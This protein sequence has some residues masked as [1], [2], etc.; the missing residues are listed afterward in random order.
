MQTAILIHNISWGH[1]SDSVEFSNGLS[2]INLSN[3]PVEKLYHHIC[4]KDGIDEASPYSYDLALIVNDEILGNKS[5]IS[6]SEYALS[7]SVLNILTILK[8]GILGFCRVIHSDDNFQTCHMTFR[9]YT[10]ETDYVD[11]LTAEYGKFENETA[12]NFRTIWNNL[13]LFTNSS[14]KSRIENAL[15]FFYFS[16]QTLSLEQT[17]ICLSIVLETLFTPNSN[18]EL[19]H[20]IAYNI[21]NFFENKRKSKIERYRYIKK[22]YSIRS[23][24]VHGESIS[25]SERLSIKDYFKFVCDL[26]LKIISDKELIL[27][28]NDNKSRIKYLEEK[29]FT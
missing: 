5:F 21:A 7:T 9:L 22:Y 17:G 8:K 4:E 29:L 13:K 20:Q 1:S 28:F 6:H 18:N 15:N 26:L 11:E 19:T 23:K 24:L 3:H 14:R 10:T 25:D 16:W 27:V 12:Q 2:F